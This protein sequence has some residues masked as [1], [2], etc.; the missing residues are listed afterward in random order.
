MILLPVLLGVAALSAILLTPREKASASPS[1][2]GTSGGA[3]GSIHVGDT[4]VFGVFTAGNPKSMDG[5]VIPGF[6]TPTEA[7]SAVGKVTQVPSAP[8]N[9]VM[10]LVTAFRAPR[11]GVL[12][13]AFQDYPISPPIGPIA[14]PVSSIYRG[15]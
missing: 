5:I 14:V 12:P 6:P 2:S 13:G 8:T 11:E 4:I 10:A 7:G 9:T 3:T 15:P 1:S